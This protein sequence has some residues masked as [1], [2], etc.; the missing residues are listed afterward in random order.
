MGVSTNITPALDYWA[1]WLILVWYSRPGF[2]YQ[3][4]GMQMGVSK[5]IPFWGAN[6]YFNYKFQFA[7]ADLRWKTFK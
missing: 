7:V 2:I 3:M 6:H 1:S 5:K 4:V